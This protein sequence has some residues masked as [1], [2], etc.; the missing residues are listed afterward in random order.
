MGLMELIL[1]VC[2]IAHPGQ[3]DDRH[4]QFASQGS[5]RTCVAD[6]EPYMAQWSN[7]HPNVHIVKWRCAYPGQEKQSL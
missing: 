1:T 3:C 2:S 4:L 6:A 5:L 7:S